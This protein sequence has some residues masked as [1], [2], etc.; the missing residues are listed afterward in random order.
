MTLLPEVTAWSLPPSLAS[1]PRSP[2]VASHAWGEVLA[3]AQSSQ[4]PLQLPCVW[5]EGSPESDDPATPRFSQFP[6][7]APLATHSHLCTWLESHDVLLLPVPP[8]CSCLRRTVGPSTQG[9]ALSR[10]LVDI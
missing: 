1:K 4:P 6:E 3:E 10:H 2:T 9:L 7:L 8:H 5:E